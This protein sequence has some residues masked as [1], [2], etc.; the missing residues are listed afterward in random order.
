MAKNGRQV[1]PGHLTEI[2]IKTYQARFLLSPNRL[3]NALILGVLG[4]AQAKYGMVICAVV[5]ASNHAHILCV[6]HSGEQLAGFCQLLKS[7]VSK[8]VGR[9]R[10]WAGGIFGDRYSDVVVTHEEA[11]Q[12]GRLRYL[13]SHGVKEGIVKRPQ[14]WPGIHCAKDLLRKSFEITGGRWIDRSGLFDARREAR[15]KKRRNR[16]KRP[17]EADFTSDQ[18]VYLSKLPCWADLDDD[19]YFERIRDLIAG[20]LEDYEDIRAKVPRDAVKRVLR[21]N[22]RHQP[23]TTKKGPKPVCHAATREVRRIFREQRREWV[24]QYRMASATLREGC[25]EALKLFPPEAFLPRL[26]WSALPARQPP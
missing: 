23:T 11:A 25:L 6:P 10:R 19:E 20:I 22:P 5:W 14:D 21:Q 8:E 3:V 2:T 1:Y 9:L 16:V 24:Q 7:N 12:I 26:P 17:S 15:A 13:L 18:I 4:Y